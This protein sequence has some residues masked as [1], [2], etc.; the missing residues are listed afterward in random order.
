MKSDSTSARG[1]VARGA[2][3]KLRDAPA[4]L[5]ADDFAR[6]A[7]LKGGEAGALDALDRPDP[8]ILAFYRREALAFSALS[9]GQRQE[10]EARE[11][12]DLLARKLVARFRESAASGRLAA[13]G[14]FARTGLRQEIPPEFW[15]DAKIEFAAGRLTLGE[16]AYAAVTVR[17][18]APN[19]PAPPPAQGDSA[20]AI[21]A[22]LDD[23]RRRRGDELKKALREAARER[24]GE[25]FTVRRFD[26]AYSAVYGRRRGRPEK[27]TSK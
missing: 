9:V 18:A 24:F 25:A 4:F 14:L 23:R 6:L 20:A 26:A 27:A 3:I 21:R 17:E 7:A 19:E 8:G 5:F 13:A 2:P 10:A 1:G 12:A 22:F 15:A 16:F 11:D